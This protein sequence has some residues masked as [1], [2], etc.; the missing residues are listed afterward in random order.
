M[1]WLEGGF[2][3]NQSNWFTLGHLLEVSYLAILDLTK[4]GSHMTG[5]QPYELK[6]E[7]FNSMGEKPDIWPPPG[8]G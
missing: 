7:S 6:L 2:K 3:G 5:R 8:E 4:L 1:A